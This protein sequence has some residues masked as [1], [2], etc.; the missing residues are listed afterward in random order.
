[1]AL[2][3]P[4]TGQNKPSAFYGMLVLKLSMSP[5]FWE[6]TDGRGGDF[7]YSQISLLHS[8]PIPVPRGVLSH[9][10]HCPSGSLWLEM[11]VT[12]VTALG[13][14]SAAELPRQMPVPR[15]KS[16]ALITWLHPQDP[17]PFYQSQV[18][19]HDSIFLVHQNLGLYVTG[20]CSPE[21]FL[22]NQ[23]FNYYIE[24][25]LEGKFNYHQ[26]SK[27]SLWSDQVNHDKVISNSFT[28]NKI[29]KSKT[30]WIW[31]LHSLSPGEIITAIWG[32]CQMHTV[33][34]SPFFIILG[35]TQISC[36]ITTMNYSRYY[37]FNMFFIMHNTYFP[38]CFL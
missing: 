32:N 6:K 1:M 22:E 21:T 33:I 3:F 31:G 36:K 15:W 24:C 17:A 16:E 34:Y 4:Q 5:P 8:L 20:I 29:R 9:S 27:L 37:T 25:C 11:D 13:P 12:S 23:V 35:V 2:P 7:A 18:C 19:S 30:C 14:G 28:Q 26:K 38:N 10:R